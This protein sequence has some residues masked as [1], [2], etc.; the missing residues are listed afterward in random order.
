MSYQIATKPH[1]NT[2]YL[3]ANLLR[4]YLQ[5]LAP[6]RPKS[7]KDRYQDHSVWTGYYP[8]ATPRPR[9][10]LL[11]QALKILV[12]MTQ[13]SARVGHHQLCMQ[14]LLNWVPQERKASPLNQRALLLGI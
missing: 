7:R 11:D 2:D 9:L 10:F 3:S 8:A 1:S 5:I 14:T 6:L 13:P 12:R 4:S